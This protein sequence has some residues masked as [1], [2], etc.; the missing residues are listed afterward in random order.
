VRSKRKYSIG[1]RRGKGKGEGEGEGK[2]MGKGMD[3]RV[4][5]RVR[6]CLEEKKYG[7]RVMPRSEDL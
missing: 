2:D 7:E 1:C 4:R 6:L 3:I 5:T